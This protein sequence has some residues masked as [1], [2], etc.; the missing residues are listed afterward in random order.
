V[1]SSRLL[2]AFGRRGTIYPAFG[3]VH[4]TFSTPFIAVVGI[5]CATILGLL[6]GDA[7]LVPS[8]EVGSMAAASGWFMA[9]LSFWMVE[10]KPAPRLITT[11]GLAMALLLLLMK[12]VPMFPG[13]FSAAEWVALAVWLGI[14]FTLRRG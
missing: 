5:A 8:T 10:K 12:L 9:C 13:H 2:F 4:E 1:A 14:G 3:K 6:L 7:I 11:L